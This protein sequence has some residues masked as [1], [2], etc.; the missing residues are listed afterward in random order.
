MFKRKKRRK[1][2]HS[3][4]QLLLAELSLLLLPKPVHSTVSIT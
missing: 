4:T 3:L 2:R 1:K